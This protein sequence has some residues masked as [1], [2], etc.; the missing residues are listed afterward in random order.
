MTCNIFARIVF[1]IFVGLIIKPQ[2]Q[3]I[4][5]ADLICWIIV[6]LFPVYCYTAGRNIDTLLILQT[7]EPERA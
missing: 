3:T 6:I 1:Y 5:R 7:R 4:G 2:N